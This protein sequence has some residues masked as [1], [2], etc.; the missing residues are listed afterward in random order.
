[1][2]CCII[3][4]D[5]SKEKYYLIIQKTG[6]T[7]LNQQTG[8]LIPISISCYVF[9]VNQALEFYTQHYSSK[10][11]KMSHLVGEWSIRQFNESKNI[12]V[13]LYIIFSQKS[14]IF[15]LNW[16]EHSSYYTIQIWER[17]LCDKAKT[18]NLSVWLVFT[19]VMLILCHCIL[20]LTFQ[21]K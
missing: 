4:W 19:W 2:I 5:W 7:T 8:N 18:S 14:F 1:M 6:I 20:F 3:H 21:L 10:V 9:I 15:H 13:W 11:N 12:T 17:F 16:F